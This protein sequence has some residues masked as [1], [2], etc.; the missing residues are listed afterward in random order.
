MKGLLV[1]LILAAGVYAGY[2]FGLPYYR[3]AAFKSDVKATARLDLGS[4]EKTK[5]QIYEAAQGLNIP[6]EEKDIIVTQKAN[7]I[8][9]VTS[10]SVD[11]DL[12]GVY[13]KKLDFKI[14]TEE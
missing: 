12:A 14:D 11:V 8:R 1:M 6:I 10:W 4:L 7:T 3:Y 2:Q 13:Q 5:K 9:V